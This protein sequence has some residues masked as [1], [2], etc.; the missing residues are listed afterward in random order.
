MSTS[1][2][3]TIPVIIRLRGPSLA[4]F[5]HEPWPNE[6]ELGQF[7]GDNIGLAVGRPFRGSV[8]FAVN[9]YRALLTKATLWAH[10]IPTANEYSQLVSPQ[11]VY[12]IHMLSKFDALNPLV[13]GL[14]GVNPWAYT[15]RPIRAASKRAAQPAR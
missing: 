4:E 1:P 10:N 2:E 12:F 9:D 7:L 11:M 5:L 8:N 6:P 3:N 13:I 14:N 15:R